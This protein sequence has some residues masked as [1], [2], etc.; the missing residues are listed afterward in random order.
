M[1]LRSL[2]VNR[3]GASSLRGERTLDVQGRAAA[4]HCAAVRCLLWLRRDEP[5]AYAARRRI[6]THSKA[7]AQRTPAHFTVPQIGTLSGTL[8]PLLCTARIALSAPS[9]SNLVA[10]AAVANLH[11]AGGEWRRSYTRQGGRHLRGYSRNNAVE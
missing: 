11:T 6:H 1:R 3:R 9:A 4:V 2:C 10:S 8:A 5:H 7:L